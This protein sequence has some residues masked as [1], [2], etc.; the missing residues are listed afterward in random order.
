MVD[1]YDIITAE[2]HEIQQNFGKSLVKETLHVMDF[3]VREEHVKMK[4]WIGKKIGLD[5]EEILSDQE[6]DQAELPKPEEPQQAAAAP[7]DA[8]SSSRPGPPPPP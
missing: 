8:S 2:Q 4:K 7:A 1:L 5:D 3:K 6:I